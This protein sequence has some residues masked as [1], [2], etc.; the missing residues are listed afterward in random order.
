MG[1]LASLHS[2]MDRLFSEFFSSPMT[3]VGEV[4]RNW[5]LPVDIVDQG[6]SLLVKAAVPGFK[7]EDV[8]VTYHDGVLNI[9]A[10]RKQESETKEGSYLRRELSVGNYSRSVQ[11]PGDIK[12]GDIKASFDNGVLTVELPKSQPVQPVKIPI[13]SGKSDKQLVGSGNNQQQ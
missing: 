11:L 1:E 4:S 8:E 7:P 2:A 12:A 10:Q 3:G 9:S 5:Y 13:G 6:N